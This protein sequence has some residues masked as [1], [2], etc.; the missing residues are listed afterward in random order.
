MLHLQPWAIRHDI[1]ERLVRHTR[2]RAQMTSGLNR[3][4][5]RSSQRYRIDSR[6]TAVI[7]IGGI[8]VKSDRELQFLQ[9]VGY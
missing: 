2:T 4:A 7:L 6:G 9:A 5:A 1:F 3:S 8:L